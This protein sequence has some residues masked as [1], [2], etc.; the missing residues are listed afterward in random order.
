M[1]DVSDGL[2]QDAGHLAAAS[3]VAIDLRLDALR[4][5]GGPGITDV[6]LLS[7]G[8]DHPLL[9]TLP[10]SA[11][12]DLHADGA[13]VVV[14]L[15]HEGGGVTVDGHRQTGPGGHDHFPAA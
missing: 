7:G 2:L 8:D 1:L 6:D 11:L 3:G 10:E 5:L 13:P 14:G 15:A 12:L 9:A 4:T